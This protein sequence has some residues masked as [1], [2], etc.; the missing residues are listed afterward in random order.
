MSRRALRVAFCLAI[1]AVART[2]ATTIVVVQEGPN[3][4]LAADSYRS[5]PNRPPTEYCKIRQYNDVV[6]ALVGHAPAASIGFDFDKSFQTVSTR[7][8][9]SLAS[10]SDALARA[11]RDHVKAL[12][13]Q[14]LDNRAKVQQEMSAAETSV[15]PSRLEPF[16]RRANE[17][18]GRID[19]LLSRVSPQTLV[20]L[21]ASGDLQVEIRII[22]P[23]H[24]KVT[25][26]PTIKTVQFDR[27][28]IVGQRDS[29]TRL[30]LASQQALFQMQPVAMARHLIETQHRSTPSEVGPPINI[31]RIRPA[32]PE[33]AAV[34]QLCR[35][36]SKVVT[37][38]A[39]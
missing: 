30:P 17:I 16:R 2:E 35:Q 24:D 18:M 20:V 7:W 37:G 33:W 38:A 12:I 19:A 26:N 5:H 36:S 1:I 15:A 21:S 39:R 6:V 3:L 13:Q 31:L 27:F 29:Y 23:T 9:G 10:K 32:G 8:S 4:L 11:Y 25:A 28:I 34:S 22:E 14:Q